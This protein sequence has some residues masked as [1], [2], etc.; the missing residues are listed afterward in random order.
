MAVLPFEPDCPADIHVPLVIV[1]AGA[2]GISAALAAVDAG[3]EPLV[4][5]RDAVPRGNTFLSSGFI[6]AAGTRFQAT[7]GIGDSVARMVADI[8]R[9]NEGQADPVI[10]RTLAENS[11]GTVEWLADRHGIPFDLVDDVRYPGH[12]VLRMHSTPR[13]TGEELIAC[14][15]GAAEA[16]GVDVVTSAR[17]C[18]LQAD[19]GRRIR[20][21]RIA[22]PDGVRETIACDALMLACNG[23]GANTELV[24][25]YLTGMETAVY[26]GHEGNQ[27]DALLWSESLGA[28]LRDLGAFQ[29]HGSLAWPHRI[30]ISWALM[31]EGGIQVNRD[32]RR[33]SNEN[34]GYSEQARKVLAQPGGTVWNVYD[35]RIHDFAMSGFEDYRRADQAG[36]LKSAPSAGTLAAVLDLPA[37]ELE[38]T[39]RETA[40]LA[41]AGAVDRFGRSFD[42]DSALK[43]PFYAV[44]VTGAVF[45]TQGG[46]EIDTSGRVLGSDRRPFPNLLAGGGAAR[47]ISGSGDSGYLSGNGLLSAMVM[48]ALAGRR[49]AA[50]MRERY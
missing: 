13:R 32:G 4:V 39:L 29:G 11:A 24:A 43:P 12:S 49:A 35:A 9:K 28:S 1:G 14:L 6:P 34:G 37:A 10:V 31:M 47:G 15:H 17:V 25:R 50:L 40:A 23:Y 33:F 2:C 3:C 41:A 36:A 27:G 7:R 44:R 48:G 45:H 16:A 19:S 5:E 30:L 46:A 42:P 18:D 22:R 21:V 8:Q 38:E 20:G 26:F